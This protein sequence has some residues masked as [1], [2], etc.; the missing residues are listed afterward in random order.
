MDAS[1][2]TG[3]STRKFSAA[4][5]KQVILLT[6]DFSY[7]FTN[8]VYLSDGQPIIDTLWEETMAEFRF[9]GARE[10]L[11]TFKQKATA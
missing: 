7:R 3:E 10:I 5:T 1:V 6:D 11:E 8:L 9:A 4:L 2:W